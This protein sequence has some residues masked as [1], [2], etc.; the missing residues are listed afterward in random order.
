MIQSVDDGGT[1]LE[2]MSTK[3]PVVRTPSTD[4][5]VEVST[6]CNFP[7][8]KGTFELSPK[9]AICRSVVS[10]QTTVRFIADYRWIV[11][12]TKRV[13]DEPPT[14]VEIVSPAALSSSSSPLTLEE[15]YVDFFWLSFIFS[16]ALLCLTPTAPTSFLDD[17]GPL[18]SRS[19]LV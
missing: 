4:S 18:M 8:H 19:K 17:V 1:W 6:V 2:E 3:T 15:R 9:R 10:C 7:K 14:I 13:D 12:P 5:H 16:C 11:P